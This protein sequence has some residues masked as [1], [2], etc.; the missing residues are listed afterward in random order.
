MVTPTLAIFA[1]APVL[2]QV[3]TRL[4]RSIGDDAALAVYLHL[5]QHTACIAGLWP[6]PVAVFVSGERALVS[7]SPLGRFTLHDQA[8]GGLG[9]RLAAAVERVDAPTMVIGVDCP[10]LQIEHLQR[11][12]SAL[13]A[14]PVA[15]GPASDGG[16]WGVAIRE[17]RS[18]GPCFADDLPWSQSDL[19]SA[20]QAR[21]DAAAIAWSL[22]DT[23]D[24]LD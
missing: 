21:L 7:A 19:L 13:V 11:L 17:P 12:S 4:A 20:T 6:G 10:G 18:I 14:A 15:F 9:A 2:G 1:R 23:L 8:D 5:V 24:D 3:K 22:V 16:Y